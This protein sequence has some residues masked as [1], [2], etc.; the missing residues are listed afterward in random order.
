MILFKSRYVYVSYIF[1]EQ[2]IAL[3]SNDENYYLTIQQ[4]KG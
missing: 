2:E 3:A 1:L 4:H